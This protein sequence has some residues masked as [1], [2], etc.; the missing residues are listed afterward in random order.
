MSGIYKIGNI[1]LDGMN[2]NLITTDLNKSNEYVSTCIDFNKNGTYCE[3]TEGPFR[4]RDTFLIDNDSFNF[5]WVSD[6]NVIVA[7]YPKRVSQENFTIGFV[8]KSHYSRTI[9]TKITLFVDTNQTRS[10]IQTLKPNEEIISKFDVTLPTLGPHKVKISTTPTT[11]NKE[12]E[13]YFWVE[14]V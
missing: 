5:F 9:D 1:N 6:K 10:K 12:N 7:H 11:I 3:K 4:E 2:F 14:R 13:I 8:M